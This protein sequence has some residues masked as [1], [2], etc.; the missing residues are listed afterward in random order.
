MLIGRVSVI[1]GDTASVGI[2]VF[3]LSVED[4]GKE[5]G[6]GKV[7]VMCGLDDVFF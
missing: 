5:E 7:D 4:G 6:T 1:T 3:N 2:N